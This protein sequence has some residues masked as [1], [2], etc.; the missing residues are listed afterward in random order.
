MKPQWLDI[1]VKAKT[2]APLKLVRNIYKL[3]RELNDIKH[4]NYYDIEVY[5]VTVKVVKER[6]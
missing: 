5:Q 2:N 4:F 3:N 1:H 6:R